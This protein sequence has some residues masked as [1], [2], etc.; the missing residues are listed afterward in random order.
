MLLPM[1]S[2][3]I[4]TSL[5]KYTRC[6]LFLPR[7]QKIRQFLEIESSESSSVAGKYWWGSTAVHSDLFYLLQHHVHTILSHILLI[8]VTTYLG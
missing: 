6:V 1:I 3:S 2:R 5:V 7:E 4:E 8:M